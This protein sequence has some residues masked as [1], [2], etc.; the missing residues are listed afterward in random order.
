MS[1]SLSLHPYIAAAAGVADPRVHLPVALGRGWGREAPGGGRCAV[2]QRAPSS[3]ALL[4][5][6]GLPFVCISAV[7][8]LQPAALGRE[9][10]IKL[11]HVR[12]LLPAQCPAQGTSQQGQHRREGGWNQPSFSDQ[13]PQAPGRLEEVGRGAE[14]VCR[15]LLLW[16][17]VPEGRS[18]QLAL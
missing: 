2:A 12:T 15:Q 17:A 3:R 10:R 4:A 13:E 5:H 8:L 16:P 14:D 1:F 9:K 18:R 6:L 11:D 7:F